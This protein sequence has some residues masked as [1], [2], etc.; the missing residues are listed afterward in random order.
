MTKRTLHWI[1]KAKKWSLRDVLTWAQ[2]TLSPLHDGGGFESIRSIFQ[3]LWLHDTENMDIA[4]IT[5]VSMRPLNCALFQA[6]NIIH[7]LSHSADLCISTSSF[8]STSTHSPMQESYPFHIYQHSPIQ[9]LHLTY[10]HWWSCRLQQLLSIQSCQCC[11]VLVSN[12]W[13]DGDDWVVSWDLC[14]N[15]S[16][17]GVG[18]SFSVSRV[19]MKIGIANNFVN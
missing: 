9:R 2:R 10:P 3:P 7:T 11:I 14:C 5:G 19:V 12:Y 6:S 13:L 16:R 1:F 17:F 18:Y 4:A 8:Y 15:D